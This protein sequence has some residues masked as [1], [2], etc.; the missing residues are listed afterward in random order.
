MQGLPAAID[1]EKVWSSPSRRDHYSSCCVAGVP[2]AAQVL[3]ERRPRKHVRYAVCSSGVSGNLILLRRAVDYK[4]SGHGTVPQNEI[5]IYTWPDATLR[6]ITDLVK[7]VIMQSV[8]QKHVSLTY[9][10]VYP[11]REGRFV[12]RTVRVHA[13]TQIFQS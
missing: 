3:L 11:D 8:K 12:L 9:A 13:T 10:L 4:D 2:A 5:Q 6:E 7:D 1:R